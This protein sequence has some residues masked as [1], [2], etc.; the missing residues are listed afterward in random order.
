[1]K[2]YLLTLLVLILGSTCAFATNTTEKIDLMGAIQK[3]KAKNY[4]GCMQDTIEITKKDPTNAVAYYY[5]AISYV[6]IGKKEKAIDAYQRVIGL[7]TN[8]TLVDYA[9]RGSLCLTNPD[10]CA[11][12]SISDLDN[13]LD[14]F[15]KGGTDVSNDVKENLEKIRLEKL[16]YNINK[17]ADLKSEM[18]SNDEIAEAVKTLAKA[19]INPL[20]MQNNPYLQ[21]QQSM[22]QNPE[23][24][25]LQML[26]GNNNHNQNNGNDF[27]S[28]LP[29]FM[30]QNNSSTSNPSLSADMLK[31]MMMSSMIGNLN[32]TFN[33]DSKN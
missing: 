28:M 26:L 5:M 1:M 16:K 11:K 2:K 18:P 17:E 14:K 10:K 31:N 15:I 8:E 21:A 27:L 6:N 25:Q 24:M 23:Y 4:V 33:F 20:Q 30:A 32:T 12:N 3:Y 9:E 19:G 7:S 13:E 29:Y 22:Y